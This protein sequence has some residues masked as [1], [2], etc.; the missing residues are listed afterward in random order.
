[1]GKT[2]GQEKEKKGF[3]KKRMSR[4][5]AK[6]KEGQGYCARDHRSFGEVLGLSAER[7]PP[8]QYPIIII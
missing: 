2:G 6:D 3:L 7:S 5:L 8:P 1:L 4:D